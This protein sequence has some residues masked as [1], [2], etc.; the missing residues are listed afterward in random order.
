MDVRGH[1]NIV[2]A[3]T[4]HLDARWGYRRNPATGSWIACR[5]DHSIAVTHGEG[6]RPSN[7]GAPDAGWPRRGADLK[8]PVGAGLREVDRSAAPPAPQA[9]N[10]WDK[11]GATDPEAIRQLRR[12]AAR[13]YFAPYLH[14]K[15]YWVPGRGFSVALV[16]FAVTG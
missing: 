4:V 9:M 5:V 3:A 8:N 6:I 2:N 12:N 15:L 10:L 7:S 16:A 1:E 11:D 14:T 13:V